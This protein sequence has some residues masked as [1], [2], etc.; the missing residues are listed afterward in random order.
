MEAHS[1]P[2]LGQ[3]TAKYKVPGHLLQQPGIYRLSARLR[4]RA[5]P[6]YFMKFVKATPEMIR[7][8]NEWIVDAHPSTV[9]FEVR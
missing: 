5:E 3:R 9:V 8:M 4:S 7:S 2:A 1:I 6:I